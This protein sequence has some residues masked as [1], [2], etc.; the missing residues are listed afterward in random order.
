MCKRVSLADAIN[1]R[2]LPRSY[3]EKLEK[4]GINIYSESCA[5]FEDGDRCFIEDPIE[6]TYV[7]IKRETYRILN[8]DV[9]PHCFP[10]RYT[11]SNRRSKPPKYR[12]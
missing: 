3:L 8:G 6:G 9:K 11:K 12:R 2:A 1:A 10:S 4:K 7:P 5:L